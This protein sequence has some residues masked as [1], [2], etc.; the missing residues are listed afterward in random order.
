[1]KRKLTKKETHEAMTRL[2][3][4]YPDA[5]AELDFKN[6][7]ELLIATILSAQ[8]TDV[9]VNLVTPALFERA[10][11]AADYA[12]LPIDELE[13]LI[14]TC[15]LYKSK[16]KNIQMTGRILAEDYGG[17]VPDTREEL[18]KLPGV[19]RKT[20]NVVLANAYG[21]PT[22]AVDTHVFRVSN[23]IGLVDAK[24]VEETEQQLM[25]YI[26]KEFWVEGHHALI[27][28]GRRVCKARKPMCEECT[29]QGLCLFSVGKRT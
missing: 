27:L 26:P 5:R 24:N 7:L 9:R 19:G 28:H 10:K 8:C 2:L 14:K 18:V 25:K 20:A 22:F 21:V 15:G 16:A 12:N 4:L 11:T 1:M 23:R 3:A 29:L 13:T 6:P 17:V